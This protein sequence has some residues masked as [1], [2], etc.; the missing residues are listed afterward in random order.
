[1]AK[2]KAVPR[3]LGHTQASSYS[4][5]L[6]ITTECKRYYTFRSWPHE[7]NLNIKDYLKIKKKETYQNCCYN[8]RPVFNC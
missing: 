2:P 4:N 3:K 7:N 8:N 5:A 1:M 6:E